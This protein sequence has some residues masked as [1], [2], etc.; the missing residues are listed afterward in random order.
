MKRFIEAELD[1]VIISA[2]E[3]ILTNS[4]NIDGPEEG[5]EDE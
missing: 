1:I 4:F 3:D 5:E 2:K